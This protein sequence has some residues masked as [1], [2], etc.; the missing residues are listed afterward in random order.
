MRV[1]HLP[2]D[3]VNPYNRLLA[4]SLESV[5]IECDL[6][7]DPPR[8][9]NPRRL[10]S[11]LRT[12]ELVHW[13]WMQSFYQGINCLKFLAR[14]VLFA[15]VLAE[16]RLR[17]IPQV[18]TVHNL[19]PHELRLEW[20][21]RRMARLIGTLTDR[22]LVHHEAAIEPVAAMYGSRAKIRV[23]PHPDYGDA[24]VSLTRTELRKKW[25]LNG[26]RTWAMV[27]GGVR[28]YKQIERVIEAAT[29]LRRH[30]VGVLVAGRCPDLA[31][32]HQLEA[33]GGDLVKFLFRRFSSDELDEL[34]IA[35]DVVLLPYAESLTSGAA[36][37]AVGRSC[38]IVC[39]RA[40]AFAEF[41]ERGL[42]VEVDFKSVDHLVEAV[43]QCKAGAFN[44]SSANSFRCE[45]NPRAVGAALSK[46]YAELGLVSRQSFLKTDSSGI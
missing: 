30:D 26:V 5:G 37:L 20:W 8:G 6:W 33:A 35:T 18:V 12:A 3:I 41:V 45:R 16:L 24:N 2:A 34:L 1:V 19:L 11:R 25:E 39:T 29:E 40:V 42:A 10:L 23:V 13:H 31:Y 32:Q 21:H 14:G 15:S 4:Q 43:N 44:T 27:F 9:R 17:G 22:L 7:F 36:H 28:E 38:P 46:V